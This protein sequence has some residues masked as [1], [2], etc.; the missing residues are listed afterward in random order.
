MQALAKLRTHYLAMAAAGALSLCLAATPAGAQGDGAYV[1]DPAYSQQNTSSIG[2]AVGDEAF[3][4]TMTNE[5][6]AE[7]EAAEDVAMDDAAAEDEA[8]ASEFA[9]DDAER[10]EVAIADE[11]VVVTAPPGIRVQRDGQLR[12]HRMSASRGVTY[13][14]LDLRTGTGARELRAR[15]RQTASEICEDLSLVPPAD[16]GDY[17]TCYRD[18]TRNALA[19][20]NAAI[21]EA[22]YSY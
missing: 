18:A 4:E 21:V 20:A 6:V 3:D 14:D 19:R 1:D 8:A 16:A 13:A 2:A 9:A 10:T 11:E 12:P 15:V 5:Q 17:G 22:R 7:D